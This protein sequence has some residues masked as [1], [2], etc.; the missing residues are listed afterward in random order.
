M[1]L[2]KKSCAFVTYCRLSVE[3]R[4]ETMPR[5]LGKISKQPHGNKMC[6]N[7]FNLIKNFHTKYFSMELAVYKYMMYENQPNYSKTPIQLYPT[8][9]IHCKLCRKPCIYDS[10]GDIINTILLYLNGLPA[11]AIFWQQY[12][13]ILCSLVTY[14]QLPHT[15][16]HIQSRLINVYNL[17]LIT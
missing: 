8:E 7:F 10:I 16:M 15:P 2:L 5:V 1:S 6:A 13:R 11:G 14:S 17:S 4:L 9:V 12:N 3:K